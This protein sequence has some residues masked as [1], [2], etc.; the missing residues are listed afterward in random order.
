MG[1][2]VRKV[3]GVC[4]YFR[5]ED[6]CWTAYYGWGECRKTDPEDP[7]IYHMDEENLPATCPF[8]EVSRINA[9]KYKIR[10]SRVMRA[11]RMLAR[12][13][14]TLSWEQLHGKEAKE[15]EEA[16]K[17]VARVLR[18]LVRARFM[19]MPVHVLTT[20]MHVVEGFANE[21]G[22][23]SVDE[24]FLADQF[25]DL[26]AEGDE[27]SATD[28]FG[29]AHHYDLAEEDAKEYSTL[30]YGEG[31]GTYYYILVR[32]GVLGVRTQISRLTREEAHRWV[33]DTIG[34]Y[35]GG[36]QEASDQSPDTVTSVK[37]RAF[38]RYDAS[39]GFYLDLLKLKDAIGA[40]Q[41]HGL[42]T[43]LDGNCCMWIFDKINS[44]GVFAGYVLVICLLPRYGKPKSVLI[45][46]TDLDQDRIERVLDLTV[47]DEDG[48]INF[49]IFREG[50][51]V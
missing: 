16:V 20:A 38:V 3:C 18:C 44:M 48:N 25:P 23:R 17:I 26:I 51:G 12:R 24:D 29:E 1:E 11:V 8:F 9:I 5:Y 41:K 50:E 33:R 35:V 30:L 27:E 36:R 40:L 4:K 7:V 39:G 13:G 31:T 49:G 43:E 42:E 21:K 45:D 32:R 37:L 10:K 28:F 15:E 46:P 14:C 2:D 47:V 6:P 19:G 22:V 34:E